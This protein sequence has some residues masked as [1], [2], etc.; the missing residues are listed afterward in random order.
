VQPVAPEHAYF[1]HA[2]RGYLDWG[3]EKGIRLSPEPTIFQLYSE[4]LQRFR[5]AA[6][7][8]GD[9]QPPDHARDRIETYFDPLPFWYPPFEGEMVD[10]GD[11][12]ASRHH[13]TADAHVP[14]L[15]LAERVAQADHGGEPALYPSRSWRADRRPR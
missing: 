4:P 15:G 5:L 10:G 13:P 11:L 1:K 6:Q 8:H 2:N 14:F 7:G 12:P 9:R 3:I